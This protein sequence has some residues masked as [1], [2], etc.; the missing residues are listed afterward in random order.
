MAPGKYEMTSSSAASL[1]RKVSWKNLSVIVALT[2]W[3]KILNELGKQ[4]HVQN[5][6]SCVNYH[7]QELLKHINHDSSFRK[8]DFS[9][10]EKWFRKKA[11]RHNK[12]IT[13]KAKCNSN[14]ILFIVT[15]AI[16]FMSSLNT[17]ATLQF[18]SFSL[19]KTF[20]ERRT[21]PDNH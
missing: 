7:I 4:F 18:T 11:F 12:L 10:R 14:L 17:A 8:Q 9:H 2:T 15:T 1:T 6:Q 19:C 21:H 20:K 13:V 3:Y 5:C 16:N